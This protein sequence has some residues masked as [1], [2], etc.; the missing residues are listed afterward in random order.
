MTRRIDQIQLINLAI[1]RLV[2]ERSSLR[3]DGN[4]A[5]LLEIHGVENLRFHFTVGQAAAM[6]NE[7]VGE[8]GLAVVNVGDD[9]KIAN[10]LHQNEVPRKRGTQE[11][12]ECPVPIVRLCIL[13]DFPQ[14]I[15]NGDTVQVVM[16]ELPITVHQDR[17]PFAKTLLQRR[18]TINIDHCQPKGKSGLQ[19]LQSGQHVVTQMAPGPAV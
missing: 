11:S 19:R 16:A 8:C 14:V 5:L 9:G 18:I 7:P 13:A 1:Q 12:P 17:H 10:M 4:A 6:L 15:S 3:L 2:A